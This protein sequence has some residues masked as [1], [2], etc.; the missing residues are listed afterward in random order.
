M[1]LII[2][3]AN[4]FGYGPAGKAIAI[5][6]AFLSKGY[7]HIVI[8]GSKFVGGIVPSSINFIELD[9]RNEHDIEKFLSQYKQVCVVSSQNRFAIRAAR[10]LGV[11]NAFL[12]GLSWFWNRLPAEHLD[13]DEIFWMNYPGIES[14]IPDK[15]KN[16]HIIPAVLGER[17]SSTSSSQTLIHIGGWQNPLVDTSESAYLDLLAQSLNQISTSTRLK[18]TGGLKAI[19]YIQSRVQKANIT[20]ASLKH[21]EFVKDLTDSSHLITTAG[22][23]ATLEAF[24][25]G[26]PVSFLLPTNLS[27]YSLTNMLNQHGATPSIM[28]WSDYLRVDDTLLEMNESEAIV[29]FQDY[30]TRIAS[31]PKLLSRFTDDLNAIITSKTDGSSQSRFIEE[32]GTDGAVRM[33]ELLFKEWQLPTVFEIDINDRP[34]KSIVSGSKTIEARVPI[35]SDKFR[36]SDMKTGDE[37]V[38]TNNSTKQ[39]IRVSVV[40]IRHYPDSISMLEKEDSSKLLSSGMG[41]KDAATS[42]LNFKGYKENM[43]RFGIYAIEIRSISDPNEIT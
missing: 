42:F 22:Q 13:A 19:A 20:F 5:A 10:S 30:A 15:A 8:A 41:S 43:P 24:Q 28:S 39:R 37:L 1:P 23:T 21:D 32:M 35:E 31:D 17:R 2:I 40:G 33:V 25:H 4:P 29:T 34:F 26:I 3:I 9:D 11:P 14:K 16:V 38:L 7:T 12:D 27:Q 18:V 6:E 36:Y